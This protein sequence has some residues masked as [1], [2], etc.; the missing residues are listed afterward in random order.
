MLSFKISFPVSSHHLC[1]KYPQRPSSQ[2]PSVGTGLR[3]LWQHTP[4]IPF[5]SNRTQAGCFSRIP[6]QTARQQGS[7]SDSGW[8]STLSSTGPT[9][10]STAL[11]VLIMFA[12]SWSSSWAQAALWKFLYVVPG[13]SWIRR[14]RHTG[15]GQK[16]WDCI[17]GNN[18]QR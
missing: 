13:R 6:L 15:R 14:V 18:S 17:F 3:W 9:C 16:C 10:S 5:C 4:K 1:V 11:T 7:A 12:T 8:F 2:H